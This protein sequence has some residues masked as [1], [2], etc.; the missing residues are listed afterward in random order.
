MIL[1]MTPSN[2][3]DPRLLALDVAGSLFIELLPARLRALKANDLRIV[4]GGRTK[5]GPGAAVSDDPDTDVLAVRDDVWFSDRA[6]VAFLTNDA[7]G[8]RAVKVFSPRAATAPEAADRELLAVYIPRAIAS[9]L[10]RDVG[11][12]A[13]VNTL[14]QLAARC[15]DARE[16]RGEELDSERPPM[17]VRSLLDV[18]VVESHI[19]YARAV[20]ALARG[21]RI[22]DPRAIAIRG[23]LQCGEDVEIDLHVIIEGKVTLGNGVRIGANCTLKSASVGEQTR[24]N[25]Y[26]M[27]ENAEIGA[28]GMVGP[29]ARVRPGSVVGDRVQI[30][31]FVE[32]KN[33]RIGSGSRINHLAFIGDATLGNNVTIGAGTITCNHDRRGVA[34]TEIGEGAYVGS[35]CLLVAP[36]SIGAN[37]TIGAGSTIT[38]TAPEGKLTIARSRQVTID[39]WTPPD[40]GEK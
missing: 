27:L 11:G 20:E 35:G 29:Y 21:V 13:Q 2:E 15:N 17:R 1:L 28:S 12:V 32:V 22:R 6:L 25:P 8:P 4:Q 40:S 36:L 19:L 9:A 16:L 34:R 24:I 18:S 37:A 7:A 26:S 23:E 39:D 10:F 33:S 5:S 14:E 38:K 31:N 3:T 30:G